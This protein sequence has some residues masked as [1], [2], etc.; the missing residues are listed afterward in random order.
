MEKQSTRYLILGQLLREFLVTPDQKISINQPG[1]NL[2]YA[3]EGLNLWLE[4]GEQIGLVARVGEDYPRIWL[5][6]LAERG[7]R[8]EGI[9]VI[10]EDIDLRY[11]ELTKTCG[12]WWKKIR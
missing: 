3:A 5:D 2:L 12:L 8:T 9:K 4:E 7:Y 1:G 10:P 6:D 11:L